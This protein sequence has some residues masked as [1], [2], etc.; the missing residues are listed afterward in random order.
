[1]RFGC[2][3]AEYGIT[4]PEQAR[5]WWQVNH[6][7]GSVQ[8]EWSG[9][10]RWLQWENLC[11]ED[12]HKRRLHNYCH[13]LRHPSSLFVCFI[14]QSTRRAAGVVCRKVWGRHNTDEWFHNHVVKSTGWQ[15]F[16]WWRGCDANVPLEPLRKHS[17]G[18]SCSWWPNLHWR[19]HKD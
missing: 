6:I 17:L 8:N 5:R 14:L 16:Q 19:P 7:S 11:R 13:H 12:D 9:H 18:I 4:L 3:G 2:W 1:M 15:I 10:G